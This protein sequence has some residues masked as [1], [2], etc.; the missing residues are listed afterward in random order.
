M[1]KA[2]ARPYRRQAADRCRR[3]AM[4]S[5]SMSCSC[6]RLRTHLGSCLLLHRCCRGLA[7]RAMCRPAQAQQQPDKNAP[8][9]PCVNDMRQIRLASWRLIHQ[10]MRRLVQADPDQSP[11]VKGKSAAKSG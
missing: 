9:R 2:V 7:H 11:L 4:H 10:T 8:S 5:C 1:L 3:T 6:W